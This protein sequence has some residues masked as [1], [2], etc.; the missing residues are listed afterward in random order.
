MNQPFRDRA[1]L[2]QVYLLLTDVWAYMRETVPTPAAFTLDASGMTSRSFPP[3]EGRFTSN[4]LLVLQNNIAK[5][6][7]LFPQVQEAIATD[8]ARNG[9]PGGLERDLAVMREREREGR[10]GEV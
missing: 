2:R 8:A 7:H 1:V 5:L 3:L 10:G 6:G 4:L 9:V